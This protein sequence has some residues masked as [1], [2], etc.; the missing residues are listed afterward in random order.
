MTD[1]ETYLSHIDEEPVAG[2]D[3]IVK[4][5]GVAFVI[6]EMNTVHINIT[7]LYYIR[8]GVIKSTTVDT[9]SASDFF[10][11]YAGVVVKGIHRES[12]EY[13]K[14]SFYDSAFTYISSI[15]ENNNDDIVFIY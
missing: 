13:T 15:N 6:D 3:N 8:N 10:Y 12:N 1:L 9:F 14:I 4:S 7:P 11:A 2:S 5:G